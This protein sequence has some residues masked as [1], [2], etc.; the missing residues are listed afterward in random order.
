MKF[1]SLDPNDPSK[2]MLS[3]LD[4]VNGGVKSN[5]EIL[6]V[7]DPNASSPVFTYIQHRFENDMF[8]FEFKM[9]SKESCP[10]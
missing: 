6:M 2:V 5:T 7:C 9:V 10:Q 3:Y 4:G 1:S 8:I